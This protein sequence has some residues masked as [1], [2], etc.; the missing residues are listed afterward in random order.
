M[1]IVECRT[2]IQNDETG[3][4]AR[5]NLIGMRLSASR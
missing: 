2:A 4:V 1:P 5:T 3:K